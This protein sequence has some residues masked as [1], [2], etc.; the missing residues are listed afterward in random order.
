MNPAAMP[1]NLQAQEGCA[2]RVPGQAGSTLAGPPSSTLHLSFL[3]G[4][5]C[6]GKRTMLAFLEQ[7]SEEVQ[8]FLTRLRLSEDPLA[9]TYLSWLQAIMLEQEATWEGFFQT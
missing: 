5:C 2:A 8:V 1:V 7:V 3:C 9:K 4:A 6:A